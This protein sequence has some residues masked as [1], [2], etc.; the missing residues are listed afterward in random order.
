MSYIQLLLVDVIESYAAFGYLQDM[1]LPDPNIMNT[2]PLL[3][4]GLALMSTPRSV[5]VGRV[6]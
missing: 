5:L 4:D 2:L 6:R 3:S 1:G